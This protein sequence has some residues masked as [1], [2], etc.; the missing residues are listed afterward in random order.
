[1]IVCC[2]KYVDAVQLGQGGKNLL[3]G[4]VESNVPE[5]RRSNPST[6]IEDVSR[7]IRS[8]DLNTRAKRNK[9]RQNGNQET[10]TPNLLARNTFQRDAPLGE[11]GKNRRTE[12]LFLTH[13]SF[14]SKY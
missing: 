5:L 4:Q 7:T 10:S 3:M 8:L 1:M 14:H 2:G 13:G 9:K 6:I 12:L 11:G